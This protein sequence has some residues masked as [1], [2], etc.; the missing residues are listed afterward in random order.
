MKDLVQQVIRGNPRA[1]ARGISLVENN[2]AAAQ[3]IM[4]KIFPYTGKSVI[5]GI[6]GSPGSGKSTLVDQ[7]VGYLRKEEKKIGIVA[8]DP[9]SP[10]SG[11]AILGDRIRMMRHSVDSEVFIRSM[12]TRGHLGGLAKATG[13]AIAIFEA[14]GKDT[15]LVETVGVGQ[16]E[17]EVVKLADIIL[18]VLTPGAGDD[19][20]IF[21]AGIM[22]IA[23]IFILN[24]AD[25]P[26]ADKMLTQL[27][28]MLELGIKGKKIPPVVKTIA[29]EGEGTDLLVDEIQKFVASRSREFQETRKKRLIYW[30]LQDIIR[31]KIYATI[32]K[33]VGESE[34]EQFINEIYK[35]E[36]DPYSAADKI[37]G[38]FGVKL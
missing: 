18:V 37:I 33:K 17:V 14:A 24:K 5:V 31:E 28:A 6:T 29:T 12:A 34:F 26:D 32:N 23:D 36:T 9:T 15:I 21:K 2:G 25:S 13:E 19:I 30:M 27:K 7:M 8:V 10:F 35:R 1:I 22:E 4:K 20:Q 11:G 38:K 3:E 16:D